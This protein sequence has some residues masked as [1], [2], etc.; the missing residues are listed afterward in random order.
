[1]RTEHDHGDNGDN[2]DHDRHDGSDRGGEL[3]PI[4][5]GRASHLLYQSQE[6]RDEHLQSGMERGM[7]ETYDRLDERIRAG[8]LELA[9][10]FAR[11]F[12]MGTHDD[13]RGIQLTMAVQPQ[14]SRAIQMLAST[15]MLISV[16]NS[17][18][19]AAIAALLALQLGAGTLGALGAGALGFIVGMATQTWYATRQIAGGARA[20]RPMFPTPPEG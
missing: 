17:V 15:L 13:A 11:F 18:L 16:L 3:H 9:P 6:H 19:L 4:H 2:G 10:D 8:Y 20:S 5:E 1:M 7:N 14:R 12:V